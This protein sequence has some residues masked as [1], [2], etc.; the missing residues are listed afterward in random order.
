MDNIPLLDVIAILVSVS[1]FTTGFLSVRLHAQR[2]RALSRAQE[3]RDLLMKPAS[4]QSADL[5]YWFADEHSQYAQAYKIDSVARFT[6]FLNLIVLLLIVFLAVLIGLK[7][8]WQ[9]TFNP[10]EIAFG[11][12][13]LFSIITIEVGVVLICFLDINHIQRDMEVQLI[14]SSHETLSQGMAWLRMGEYELARMWLDDLIK[15]HPQWDASWFL[16]GY[17]SY[18]KA[19]ELEKNGETSS[20]KEYHRRA[21]DDL[22]KANDLQTSFG[23]LYR[24]GVAAISLKEY[25]KA[26]EH[27]TKAITMK[28]EAKVLYLLRGKAYE[29]LERIEEAIQ[30]YNKAKSAN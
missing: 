25:D 24:M 5:L 1:V 12:Y 11:F 21:Y 8:N 29:Q 9:W 2:D 14:S 4:M 17:A 6:A 28:P 15:D 23:A 18:E 10:K 13:A 3:V 16:R 19:R 7:E 27:L 26:V 22:K 30:D 20:A